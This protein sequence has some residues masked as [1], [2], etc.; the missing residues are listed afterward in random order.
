MWPTKYGQTFT[1]VHFELDKSGKISEYYYAVEF[2][3]FKSVKDEILQLFKDKY[4]QEPA[5]KKPYAG[6]STEYIVLK[7]KSPSI[8]LRYDDI[9]T[10]WEVGVNRP[11]L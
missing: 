6:S 7:E 11:M 5:T 2:D 4:N 10:A 3:R 9:T 1:R 8:H